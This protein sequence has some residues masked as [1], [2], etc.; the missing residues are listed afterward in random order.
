MPLHGDMREPS[1]DQVEEGGEEVE[2]WGNEL[3]EGFEDLRAAGGNVL[4][5]PDADPTII[6]RVAE[7]Q[8][9]GLLE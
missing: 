2:A 7:R 3:L 6:M 5:G 1:F 8:F 4:Q 9:V